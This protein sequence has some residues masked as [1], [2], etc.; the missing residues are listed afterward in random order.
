MS[1]CKLENGVSSSGAGFLAKRV[2]K[3]LFFENEVKNCSSEGNGAFFSIEEVNLILTNC[4]FS[5]LNSSK[6]GGVVYGS[7]GVDVLLKDL[8]VFEVRTMS[9]GLIFLQESNQINLTN[10]NLQNQSSITI[11]SAIHVAS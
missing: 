9:G 8:S 11:S 2:E 6:N 10:I 7:F 5:N 4:K 1:A 3:L